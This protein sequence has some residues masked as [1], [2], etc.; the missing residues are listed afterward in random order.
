[1]MTKTVFYVEGM[2][3]KS[4]AA[5]IEQACNEVGAIKVQVDLVQKQVEIE[6]DPNSLEVGLLKEQVEKLGYKIV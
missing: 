6:H 3:C 4:C 5:K 1:M 2:S